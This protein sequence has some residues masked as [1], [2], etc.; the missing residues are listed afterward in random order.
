MSIKGWVAAVACAMSLT[1]C[2][3]SPP[4]PDNPYYAP[5][6]VTPVPNTQ[7]STGSIYNAATSMNLYGDG[8]AYR[9]GDIITVELEESTQSTKSSKTSVD[10]S[11]N[12]DVGVGS[13]MGQNLSLFGNPLS[14]SL[15][16]N[17]AFEGDGSSDMSNS[18]TGSITVTVH[19]VRP[20][21]NLLV[22]GEKWL[23]LNQ[24]DEYIRI[25]GLIRPQDIDPSNTVMS[26]KLA[27]ARITYSGTGAVND[28]N[29]MGWLARFFISPLFPF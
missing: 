24:G 25:S 20:N 6:P 21:G 27:D 11:S 8:R 23:T 13:V 12:T 14:A 5:V 4:K 17:H 28:S 1:G 26:T 18:L 7:P 16:S 19:E 15:G 29:V 9:V 22:R 3:N 2:V 10:K